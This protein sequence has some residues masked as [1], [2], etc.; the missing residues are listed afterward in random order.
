MKSIVVW[1]E[2]PAL[3][4]DRC[5]QFYETILDVKMHVMEMG[6]IKHAFF[7][8]EGEAVGGAIVQEDY[9]KPG[10]TGPMVYLNGGENLAIVLNRVEK[11]GGKI[12]MP[13]KLISEH[14]GY[15]AQ[16]Y[17]TEGNRL[18]LYEAIKQE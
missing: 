15:M 7:P 10:D 6:G 18:A 9:L 5:L 4:F 17:D 16:F 3:D 12:T 8:H 1:F 14:V 13:K 2:I 11:A